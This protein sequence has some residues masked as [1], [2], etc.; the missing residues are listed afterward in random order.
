MKVLIDLVDTDLLIFIDVINRSVRNAAFPGELK[1]AE[2]TFFDSHMF[3]KSMRELFSIK[4]VQN[5]NRTFLVCL[6]VFAKIL[7]HNILC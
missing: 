6:I 5:F 4:L 3:K 7:T 2:V 1:L